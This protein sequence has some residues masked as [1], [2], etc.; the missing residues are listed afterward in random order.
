MPEV[1]VLMPVYNVREEYLKE[2]VESILNQTFTDFEFIILDDCSA[3]DI[4]GVIRAYNDE[5]IKY[6]RNEQNL[7]IAKS[8]NKLME[9]AAGKYAA[10]MDNDDISLPQR[11]EKQ[12]AFLNSHPEISV[13]SSAY[14]MFPKTQ[15]VVHPERVSYIDLIKSCVVT[16]PSVMFRLADFRKFDLTYNSEYICS[17]DYELWSR[18]IRFLKIA[19]LKDVLLRYR[20][21]EG[22]ITRQ[23]MDLAAKEDE[24]IR[25]N[26]LDFLTS[27]VDMQEKIIGR[28][29]LS[30][31]QK[32]FS[33]RNE[34]QKKVIRV[35]GAKVSLKRQKKS[36][37]EKLEYFE[38]HLA[39]HCNLNCQSC[40]HFSPL[41]E[42]NFP[43]INEYERDL[44]RISQLTNKNVGTMSLMGGEPLLNK[45]CTEYIKIARK[46][47]PETKIQL[48][49]NGIL[50]LSM[51][52]KF[53]NVMSENNIIL[54]PTKYP[55]Q[56]DWN[57][58]LE[59]CSKY[60]VTIEFYNNAD[61]LKT[62]FRI[63]MCKEGKLNAKKQFSKCWIA[64]QCIFL[65]K[66]KLY[67]CS[68]A[69]N[70]SY[71]NKHFNL[72]LPEDNGIDIYEC[73]N[74]QEILEFLNKPIPL[75]KHCKITGMQK[76]LPWRVSKK[77]LEEW[78]D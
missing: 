9:L 20:V 64:K 59:L 29:S 4:S 28:K 32:L 50:L 25:Q 49:T 13:V 44:K 27:D 36:T 17:Q 75:C 54:R 72:N 3:N 12:V 42:A 35:F 10:L 74:I 55:I 56:V 11:L 15:I 21:S 18:A 57:R 77:Q 5:R 45:Q 78:L 30:L 70:I 23:K 6:F 37:L 39:E 1:S 73:D 22:N 41:A 19:N 71:F 76:D 62:S 33:V 67:T 26:M 63:P 16:H 24:Q 53:W 2:A 68:Y 61:V 43:D 47:F 52:E 58:V 69:G 7:G 65:S 60:G 38:V 14:E 31:L 40:T 8:R 51:D 34:G 48:V 46:Y 66:G